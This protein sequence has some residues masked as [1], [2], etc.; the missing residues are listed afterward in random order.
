MMFDMG[1]IYLMMFFTDI[2]GISAFYG[3]LVFLVAKSLMHL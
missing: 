1:Q 3:G 2:L